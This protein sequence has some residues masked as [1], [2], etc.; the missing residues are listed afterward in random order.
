MIRINGVQLGPV[1]LG[2]FAG[3]AEQQD[4]HLGTST[5]F[6]ALVFS[7]SLRLA[8]STA[9]QRAALV[10]SVVELLEL[11][12]LTNR[13]VNSLSPAE[14]KRLTIGVE[15]SANP[16]ILF[17][18]E[19]TTGLDARSAAVV[20]RAI[21]NVASTGRTVICT[22]HQPSAELFFSFDALLLLAP[23]GYPVYAGPLGHRGLALTDYLQVID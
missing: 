18:D 6:E 11:Q 10:E 16:S 5:V 23:G 3:F 15:L 22:V 12:P 1:A 2:R 21:R 4:V 17:L 19:P 14:L 9:E 13:M 7:C 20:M 8:N